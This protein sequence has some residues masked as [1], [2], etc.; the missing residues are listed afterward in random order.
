MSK[1]FLVYARTTFRKILPTWA[2][3]GRLMQ[4][5]SC[6]RE[7]WGEDGNEKGYTAM[8]MKRWNMKE[9]NV[10]RWEI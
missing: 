8:I 6:G 10:S 1:Y 5:G 3:Q 2:L 4:M 7:R 9:V